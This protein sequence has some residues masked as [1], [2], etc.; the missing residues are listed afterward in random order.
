[1]AM[2]DAASTPSNLDEDYSPSSTVI[3]FERPIPLLRGPLPAGDSDDPSAGPY[4]LAFRDS[5]AWASS[6]TACERKIVHQCEEGA[7][8]GCAINA[9]RYCKPPWWKA[10]SGPKPE[11]LKEREL[12]EEREMAGCFAEAKEKCVGMARGK[13]LVPFRDAR[14]RIVLD[15]KDAVRLI[16]QAS[17]PERSLWVMRQVGWL[18]L[19]GGELG[20][21]NRRASEL[22]G[23]DECVRC[24]LGDREQGTKI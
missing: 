11:D 4:I 23:F 21:T 15:S 1:M 24:I 17:M 14:I 10:L 22:V 5:Q 20:V 19:I 8:V 12:C 6:F 3:N 7:R 2:D 18:G 9:S 16:G 13:C